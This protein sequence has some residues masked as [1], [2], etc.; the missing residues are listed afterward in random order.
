MYISKIKSASAAQLSW[1]SY[2]SDFHAAAYVDLDKLIYLIDL[3]DD[4]TS[5]QSIYQG[6]R[7]CLGQ[8]VGLPVCW[9]LQCMEVVHMFLALTLDVLCLQ[10]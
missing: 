3:L 4:T 8:S 5:L 7:F 9:K 6:S 10:F 1:A 2:F